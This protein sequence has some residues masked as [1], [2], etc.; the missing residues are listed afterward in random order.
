MREFLK[1]QTTFA[2]L[3]FRFLQN[4][5]N[6]QCKAILNGIDIPFLYENI[7]RRR[8]TLIDLHSSITAK[9][10]QSSQSFDSIAPLLT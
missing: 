1:F 10:L 5:F 3:S 4:S 8:L 7:K 9:L 6:S 2:T